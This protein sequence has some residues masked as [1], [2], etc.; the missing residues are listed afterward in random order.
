MEAAA[1]MS[2]RRR[3]RRRLLFALLITGIW[4]VAELI[5]GLLTNS[6]ALLADAA[7]MFTDLAALGLSLFA[8]NIAERPATH[9]KTY[10]YLRA[11]ILAA[12]ANGVLLVLVALY[13][14][15]EAWHRL[16]APEPVRSLEM[17]L[18]AVVGL[19]ANLAAMSMLH[20]H[21]HNLNIRAAFLHILGDTMGS[22]GTIVAGIAMLVWQWYLADSLVSVAVGLLVLYGSVKLVRESVDVL[23]EGTPRNV[24]VP[25]IITD[26]GAVEGVSSIHE[27]HVWL[28]S[29]DVPAMSCHVVLTASGDGTAVLTEVSRIM[30]ERHGITHTTVQ[31]ERGDWNPPAAGR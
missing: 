15:Y 14:F 26:I 28:L 4:F 27:L 19:V 10:G 18:I 20:S 17:L 5:G 25:E 23:L 12:L 11:E 8:L 9:R 3:S 6:L 22:V 29:S 24:S 1:S 30:R 21:Q 7:H 2:Q 16:L 31:I 13:I